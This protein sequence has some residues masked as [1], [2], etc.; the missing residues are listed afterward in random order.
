VPSSHKLI[1][2]IRLK[3][4]IRLVV[5]EAHIEMYCFS[6]ISWPVFHQS[7]VIVAAVSTPTLNYDGAH[8]TPE[9]E[10][11]FLLASLQ[12]SS[13]TS[14][15]SIEI[16][17]LKHMRLAKGQPQLLMIVERDCDFEVASP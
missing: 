4:L 9:T 10:S 17:R 15:G 2:P 5:N 6:L 7:L 13:P 3:I 16:R 14:A 12:R 8:H 11:S 1:I